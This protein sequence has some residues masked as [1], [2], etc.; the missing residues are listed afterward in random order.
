MSLKKHENVQFDSTC[1]TAHDTPTRY[2]RSDHECVDPMKQRQKGTL[3][4]YY[5]KVKG[6]WWSTRHDCFGNEEIGKVCY[7]FHSLFGMVQLLI[8][9]LSFCDLNNCCK[10]KSW[11]SHYLYYQPNEKKTTSSLKFSLLELLLHSS[12]LLHEHFHTTF[13]ASEPDWVR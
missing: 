1:D 9:K 5:Y 8:A 7:W 10:K 13:R 6:L 12:V 11:H 3:L 4:P 2:G